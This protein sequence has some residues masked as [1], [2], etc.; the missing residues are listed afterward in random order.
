VKR[1]PLV[2]AL[3]ACGSKPTPGVLNVSDDG[4][5][6]RMTGSEVAFKDLPLGD[7]G[8]PVIGAKVDIDLRVP[9]AKGK[10]DYSHAT[11]FF[12]VTCPAGC[13]I[14]DDKAK[15]VPSSSPRNRAFVGDGIEFGHVA[16]DRVDVRIELAD[17]HAKISRWLVGSNDLAIDLTGDVTLAADLDQSRIDACLRFKPTEA[18][19]QRDSK[20]YNVL[21]LTGAA[22]DA[23]GDFAIHLTDRFRQMR[24]TS[25]CGPAVNTTPRKPNLVP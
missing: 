2:V 7:L 5:E 4:D 19:R 6:W 1:I 3:V 15:I 25:G 11:G 16:L 18:L 8:L 24:R 23:Q 13:Q 9:I 10:R 22:V 20:T 12:A 14:G 17:G 21:S